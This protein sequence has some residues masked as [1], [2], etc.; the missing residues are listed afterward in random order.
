MRVAAGAIFDPATRVDLKAPTT[1]TYADRI[2][3]GVTDVPRLVGQVVAGAAK[4][5]MSNFLF[6]IWA[7]EPAFR[8]R[9][10]LE[11]AAKAAGRVSASLVGLPSAAKGI[12]R[13]G[14]AIASKARAGSE[15]FN[16]TG[17]HLGGAARRV[18]EGA[19][20]R[21]VIG[22]NMGRVQEAAK[23]FNAEV[24]PGMIPFPKNTPFKVSWRHNKAWLMDKIERGYEII[25]IGKDMDQV[26]RS[27][28]YTLETRVIAKRGYQRIRKAFY[29]PSGTARYN[30]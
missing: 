22:Q 28:W 1:E 16:T 17:G 20:K 11:G 5:A 13:H 27:A 8:P 7:D 12:G 25:D 10:K 6:G 4:G 23:L 26:K 3:G 15:G 21:I 29:P 30:H 18:G 9:T 2:S 14:A 19:P 24:Y